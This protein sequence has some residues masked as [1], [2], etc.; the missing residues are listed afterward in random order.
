MKQINRSPLNIVHAGLEV[1]RSEFQDYVMN[2]AESKPLRT[3][4]HLGSN[5]ESP[6]GLWLYNFNRFVNKFF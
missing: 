1:L 2:M 6:K 5:E 3:C 4:E